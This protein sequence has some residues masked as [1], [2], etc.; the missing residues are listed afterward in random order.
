MEGAGRRK[1]G[2]ACAEARHPR[3]STT[4]TLPH[5]TNQPR[6]PL[7]LTSPFPPLQTI[8]GYFTRPGIPTRP[9]LYTVTPLTASRTFSTLSVTAHQPAQ[10][11]TN[12]LG[13]HFP[14]AADARLPLAPPCFTALCSFKSPAPHSMGVSTQDV[15]PQVRFAE[16]LRLRRPGEW[17]PAPPV[18][19]EGIVE[20]VG[21]E[22][23]GRF[24][25]AEM[26]KVD[27][28]AWNEGRE[29][30]E[31]RE[32]LLYRLWKPL[33]E[34]D[35]SAHVAAHAY[36]ADRNGLLVAGNHVGFGRAFGRAASLSYSLV[37]HVNAEE[38]VMREG[39][40]QWWVQ[41]M[42][43]PRVAAGRGV[44]ES[45]IWSPQGVHVATEYQDGLIQGA[46]L[47][48]L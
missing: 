29:V 5:P 2:D 13:D 18:D 45:K 34:G 11:S 39:E 36:V 10:P 7:I 17:P 42:W 31:R 20:L 32:L 14:P 16:V 26:R 30:G 25:V 22:Q 3:K 12:P 27:M 6:T 21:E 38:A 48:K 43:F 41:E 4:T 28:R 23:E 9:F 15:P 40:D 37:V 46:G 19:I 33:P 1:G 24:P 35:T 44:V 8:H 47:G